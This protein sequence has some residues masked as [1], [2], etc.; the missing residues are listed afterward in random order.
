[1]SPPPRQSKPQCPPSSARSMSSSLDQ[2]SDIELEEGP[3]YGLGLGGKARIRKSMHA[4]LSLPGVYTHAR[5]AVPVVARA[6][7]RVR[8]LARV[9]VRT[10]KRACI[11]SCAYL[12]ADARA[13]FCSVARSR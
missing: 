3:G 12:S 11:R 2:G 1:M 4:P 7:M 10:D 13:R 9:C 6:W 8:E 5:S